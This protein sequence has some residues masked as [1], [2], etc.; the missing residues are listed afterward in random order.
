MRTSR[1]RYAAMARQLHTREVTPKACRRPECR[2]KPLL[3]LTVSIVAIMPLGEM[4]WMALVGG[5]TCPPG[6][7]RNRRKGERGQRPH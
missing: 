1:V 4:D 2:L 6:W 3:L 5:R 7:Q